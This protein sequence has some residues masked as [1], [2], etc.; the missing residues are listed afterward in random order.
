MDLLAMEFDFIDKIGPWQSEV[1]RWAKPDE[2]IQRRVNWEIELFLNGDM[3]AESS[4]G[5]FVRLKETVMDYGKKKE[6]VSV[7]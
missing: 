3:A 6:I 5:P 2:V 4:Y 7:V 1:H